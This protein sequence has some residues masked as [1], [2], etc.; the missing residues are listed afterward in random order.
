MNINTMKHGALAPDDL[1]LSLVSS[2]PLPTRIKAVH[3][4]IALDFDTI[5]IQ[6][7]PEIYHVSRVTGEIL[8]VKCVEGIRATVMMTLWDQE[9]VVICTDNP[10]DLIASSPC[11]TSEEVV[12]VRS[13]LL[14]S[15]TSNVL[16]QCDV[17]GLCS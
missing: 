3:K 8:N 9:R 10:M 14:F 4:A 12:S 1:F 7:L 16:F 15:R 6:T 11:G 5:L 2:V 17:S 13:R